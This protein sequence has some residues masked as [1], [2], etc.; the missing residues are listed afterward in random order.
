MRKIL[1][2]FK[3]ASERQSSYVTGSLTDKY[4]VFY[5]N[6]NDGPQSPVGV[7][8]EPSIAS[9][10]CSM[11]K[12]GCGRNGSEFLDLNK[13]DGQAIGMA[14]QHLKKI[15]APVEGQTVKEAVAEMRKG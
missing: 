14:M 8:D 13:N 11:A 6:G 7:S 5:L 4:R 2:Y 1:A 15:N 3:E 10:A 12:C 9:H